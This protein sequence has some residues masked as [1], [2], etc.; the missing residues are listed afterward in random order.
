M[1]R[2]LLVYNP[3]AGRRRVRLLD[4]ITAILAGGGWRIE[5]QATGGPGAATELARGAAAAGCEA[6]FAFGGDGTLRE[7]A[8]GL[9]GSDVPLGFLPA[10]TANVMRHALRLPRHAV[11]AAR[12][13]A[14]P[15]GAPVR[16]LD[17]GRCA[18]APFLI[19]ASAGM[20]ARV[21]ANLRPALKRRLG[22]A[23]G[24]PAI[25]GALATYD[26]PAL[27]I[28]A[29]G[30]SLEGSWVTVSNVPEYGGRWRLM[31]PAR[32]DDRALDLLVFHGSGGPATLGIGMQILL[33]GG[34]HLRR[35][36]VTVRRVERVVIE[37]PAEP[38]LQIDGDTFA[39]AAP[40]EIGLADERLRVL[41]AG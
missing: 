40:V 13:F 5:R 28:R 26:Y 37:G 34:R 4:R 36:D 41:T 25:L 35:R 24:F 29:D 18:G 22:A 39:A 17:V 16:L 32:P 21:V 11:G 6:V 19:L 38:P 30:E 20:D 2:A 14:R 12:L 3:V 9:L 23:A 33:G 8:A 10:G 31:P 1:S 27:R 15:G 7:A